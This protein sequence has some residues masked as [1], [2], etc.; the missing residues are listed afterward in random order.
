M[1][2]P[3]IGFSLLA[4]VI[5]AIIVVKHYHATHF[6]PETPNNGEDYAEEIMPEE[7]EGVYGFR[8]QN[9]FLRHGVEVL[10]KL[11]KDEDVDCVTELSTGALNAILGSK[12]WQPLSSDNEKETEVMKELLKTNE[13]IAFKGTVKHADSD[14]KVY[15]YVAYECSDGSIGATSI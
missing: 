7:K 4:L 3:I 12:P 9:V 14:N 15:V 10:T 5:V 1:I 13:Y 2:G 6:A 11:T 8:D